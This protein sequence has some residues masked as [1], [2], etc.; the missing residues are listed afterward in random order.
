[1]N[2][3]LIWQG[4]FF[5]LIAGLAGI[6]IIANEEILIISL[7]NVNASAGTQNLEVPINFDNNVT[8]YGIQFSVPHDNDLIF[9]NISLTSRT[10][11][12]IVDA[13]DVDGEILIAAVKEDG[14]SAGNGTILNLVF[15][16]S[17][18]ANGTYPLNVT[19]GLILD[20]ST[21]SYLFE[22]VPGN[23]SIN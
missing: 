20:I 23:V 7:E 12:A 3:K 10:E 15:D 21:D 17:A 11:G 4:I 22:S 14:I 5:V 16:V 6:L 18:S 19:N 13:N 8:V 1:M 9:K 2:E